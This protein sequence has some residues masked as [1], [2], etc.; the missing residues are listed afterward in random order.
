MTVASACPGEDP[1]WVAEAHARVREHM[2]RQET[3]E[4]FWVRLILVITKSGV[5]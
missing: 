2:A 4:L 1:C 3:Q 5:L